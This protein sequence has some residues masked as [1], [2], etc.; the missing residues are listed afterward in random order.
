[1]RSM[2]TDLK[3]A[4]RDEREGSEYP[5]RMK[6]QQ[7]LAELVRRAGTKAVFFV[8]TFLSPTLV[9]LAEGQI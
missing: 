8:P 1:M 3:D 2:A 7:F 6:G 5:Q 9:E 4:S